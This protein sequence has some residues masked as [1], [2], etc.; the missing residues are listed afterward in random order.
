[1]KGVSTCREYRNDRGKGPTIGKV[2]GLASQTV[3]EVRSTCTCNKFIT[4]SS[5]SDENSNSSS[6]D[7]TA[8]ADNME[9]LLEEMGDTEGDDVSFL[10]G[11]ESGHEM[12][13]TRKRALLRAPA[14][15]RSN[16]GNDQSSSGSSS[17]SSLEVEDEVG[18]SS[19]EESEGGEI[20]DCES[21][22]EEEE[23]ENDDD[24]EAVQE[25]EGEPLEEL[26]PA[27][28]DDEDS[29]IDEDEIE[30]TLKKIPKEKKE[31]IKLKKLSEDLDPND[32]EAVEMAKLLGEWGVDDDD[33]NNNSY[34][35][36]EDNDDDD[37]SE[38][39]ER[40]VI[41]D[42]NVIDHIVLVAPDLDEATKNFEKMTGIAPKVCGHINGLGLRC[43]RV[44]F[45]DSSFI[46]IIAPDD[47][48]PGPIGTLIKSRGI[49]QLTPFHFA[50]RT[51]RAE[52][53]KEEVK[54][55]GY[56]P[57]HI[58]MFSGNTDGDP[59]K[60]ELLHLYGH[61]LGGICPFLWTGTTQSTPARQSLLWV[62]SKS[63]AFGLPL[64]TLST[65]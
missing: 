41:L 28:D 23:E 49:K 18:A 45:N 31:K 43:A 62:N 52:E 17:A 64:T 54:A 20:E 39:S 59:K 25:E 60:W 9:A 15:S 44:S 12:E 51:N 37:E 47:K 50:I 65:A 55:F 3:K 7:Q 1:M 36:S 21:E 57:D 19:E 10:D 8:E 11:S 26:A 58:T 46:E 2:T 4:M 40:E 63:L 48:K 33:D 6:S 22:P 53:L 14:S 5:S 56:T 16:D 24:D 35:D 32:A 29:V 13:D 61:K 38:A 27:P 30:D 34:N 42:P